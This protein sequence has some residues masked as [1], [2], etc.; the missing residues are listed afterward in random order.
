MGETVID[1]FK[2]IKKR[3]NL[4]HDKKV[5]IGFDGFIDNIVRVIRQKDEKRQKK[6]FADIGQFG[7][8][9]S[10]RQGKS[11]SIEVDP[12]TTKIGGNMPILANAIGCLGIEVNCIGA[13]GY[14]QVNPVFKK[15]SP[16]C[17]LLSYANPGQSTALEFND[18]KIMIAEMASIN[19]INWDTV[20]KILGLDI[21][22]N[23]YNSN[24][25][26]G[27][28][29]WGEMDNSSGIWQGII[30]EV[31]IQHTPNKDQI[32][33]FDLSDGSKRSNREISQALSLIE[34]FSEH[35]KVVLSL[36]EN[37]SFFVFNNI[38]PERN[39]EKEVNDIGRKI[40]QQLKVDDL[41][42]HTS[43][44]SYGWNLDGEYK[45]ETE[46]IKSPK[47]LT[48]GGD[49]FNAGICLAYLLDFNLEE[50]LFI[51]NTLAYYY[52]KYGSSPSICELMDYI[53]NADKTNI[54]KQAKMDCL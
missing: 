38:Y 9:V 10:A 51:G 46:F 6:Y 7:G 16:N 19:N 13:M 1:I 5:T 23:I 12:L 53:E 39:S 24:D 42:I 22:K 35:F 40:F 45:A 20:K 14:P 11:F 52:I 48:G 8:Y 15:M 26:I 2:V 27:M 49:N 30:K 29:N 43:R 50:S 21:I 47:I 33:F 25:F 54:Q 34:E 37:E 44:C 31:L 28:V 17:E 41:I 36:N 32:V 4:L 3:M 18:G